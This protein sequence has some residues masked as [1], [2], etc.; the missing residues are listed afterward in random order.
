MYALYRN[1]GAG[2]FTASV[3]FAG[4]SFEV[5]DGSEDFCST[6][7]LGSACAGEYEGNKLKRATNNASRPHE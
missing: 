3:N 6:G 7:G 1:N 2:T 4:A 5:E